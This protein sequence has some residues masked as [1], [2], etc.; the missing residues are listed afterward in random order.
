MFDLSQP[1]EVTG[2]KR[3]LFEISIAISAKHALDEMQQALLG[4]AARAMAMRVALE[5]SQMPDVRPAFNFPH[6]GM[7][8]S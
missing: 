3:A 1:S 7:L 5:V 8:N 4:H 6:G 2:L